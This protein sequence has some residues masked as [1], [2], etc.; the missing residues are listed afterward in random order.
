MTFGI[1]LH[2]ERGA[3]ATLAEAR[4][5]DEQGYD[6]VWLYDHLTN[7]RTGEPHVAEEPLE[8][9]TLMS[10]IGATTRR[11]RLAFAMLNTSFRNPALLAK[12]IA[13]LDQITHGRVICSVGAGW[14]EAEFRAYGL[15][16]IEG[17][18]DRIAYAREVVQLF[19]QL[20]T[21]PAPDRVTFDGALVKT[22]DLPFNPAP[23]QKPHPPIWIGGDSDATLRSVKELGDGWVMTRGPTS[24]DGTRAITTQP[25][26][27]TRPM[28]VVWS[29]FGCFVGD[30]HEDAIA[31]AARE[32]VPRGLAQ[33]ARGPT[34]VEEYMANPHALA[35][36]P[37]ECVARIR[38]IHSW[39][40]NYFRL[41]FATADLQARF[42]R[43]VLPRVADLPSAVA[44]AT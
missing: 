11:T 15:P 29:A 21:H 17:H 13:T 40:Y 30:T 20:W 6:S 8:S 5:A 12:M 33:G 32:F 34:S 24:A 16:F 41:S 25:D 35:G 9:W 4:A 28:T 10:A 2:A 18:D 26:W 43:L 38:E 7:F 42:A 3:D 22:R 39:G 23:Y 31:M 1:Q 36:T 37:D 14:L 44:G 27:P 19:K